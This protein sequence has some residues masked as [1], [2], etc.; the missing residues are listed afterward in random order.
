MQGFK[1]YMDAIMA[2]LNTTATK[3]DISSINDKIVAQN[4]E[5]EQQVFRDPDNAQII[6]RDKIPDFL[7]KFFAEIA[8]KTRGPNN[9]INSN[10]DRDIYNFDFD[11]EGFDLEPVSVETVLE[12][13][14]DIDVNMSSCVE[15]VNMKICKIIL[16]NFPRKIF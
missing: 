1:T 16:V 12:C 11:F 8:K 5:I 15:S 3:V 4:L 9:D 2:R 10:V 13:K 6:E 7:N 14:E